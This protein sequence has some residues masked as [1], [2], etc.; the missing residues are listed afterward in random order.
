M[1]TSTKELGNNEAAGSTSVA[2]LDMKLEVVVIPVSDVDRAKGFY[3]RLG[4]RLDADRSAGDK[5]RLVTRS[6]S[7]RPTRTGQI[8]TPSTWCAAVWRRAATINDED[9]P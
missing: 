4:W 5:F 2:N 3:S 1:S 6:A 9:R 7:G 8:G